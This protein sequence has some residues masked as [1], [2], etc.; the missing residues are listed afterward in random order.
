MIE[1]VWV[2]IKGAGKWVLIAITA[3]AATTGIIM[4]MPEDT[5]EHL[6]LKVS[7][8][9]VLESWNAD[10]IRCD[11]G[12]CTNY[13]QIKKYS[14]TSDVEVPQATYDGLTEDISKR[15]GNSQH[16]KTGNIVDGKEELKM[17]AYT[18]EP[19]YKGE[20]SK[21]KDKW[22]QTETSTTTIPAFETQTLSFFD[23]LFKKTYAACPDDPC[24]SGAG[25]GRVVKYFEASWDDAHNATTGDEAD[26]TGT[27]TGIY[28][29]GSDINA[30][31]AV[32][33]GFFPT[34]TSALAGGTV[35]AAK[36]Y[37][38]SYGLSNTDNDGNDYLAVVG[39]TT[40]PDA[41]TLTTA[42]IELCGDTHSPTVGSD[43]IDFGSLAEG[44]MNFLT[45]NA[46]GRGW[47]KTSAGDPY[48]MIGVREGHDIL[49]D[50]VGA[51]LENV[52]TVRFSEYTGTASDPYLDITYTPV[53][54][55]V[56]SVMIITGDE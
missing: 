46:T 10:D 33:K 17:R 13:G 44:G 48:T 6:L 9:Q 18:G 1:K 35:T 31:W 21:D 42:D 23:K 19:F 16:F 43:T 4:T 47:I 34:D 8:E 22:Y 15:T 40:Q 56:N 36:L 2:W 45:L 25:D 50:P 55:T 20:K 41:T 3:V 49:D 29:Q 28:V 53:A 7:K 5:P 38:Y 14:Y 24:Y 39:E 26:P 30:G 54:A 27:A 51:G 32:A 12:K 52:L 11:D 37:F